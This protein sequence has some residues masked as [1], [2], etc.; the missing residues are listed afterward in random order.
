MGC[1]A[2]QKGSNLDARPKD[3]RLSKAGCLDGVEE[4]FTNWEDLDL[5]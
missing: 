1:E 5:L 3:E 2:K 4:E